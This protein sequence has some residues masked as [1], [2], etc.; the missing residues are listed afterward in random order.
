MLL[1]LSPLLSGA[2]ILADIFTLI[3]LSPRAAVSAFF[4]PKARATHCP[5]GVGGGRWKVGERRGGKEK[6]KWGRSAKEGERW[7]GMGKVDKIGRA[8]V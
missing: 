4:S 5:V 2:D 7:K 6:G 1:A 3:S 8:H